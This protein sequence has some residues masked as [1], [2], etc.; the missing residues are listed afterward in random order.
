MAQ[1][2]DIA[3]RPTPF[4][5]YLALAALAGYTMTTGNFVAAATTVVAMFL[6]FG[7]KHHY[8][9]IEA[10]DSIVAHTT[11]FGL[12]LKKQFVRLADY[13]A[14]R[15]RIHF[16]GARL[17]GHSCITEL[18]RPDG[19]ILILREELI[20]FTNKIPADAEALLAKVAEITKLRKG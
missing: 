11:L 2:I 13:S 3:H 8:V 4:T 15:N 1:S 9:V 10:A 17:S 6:L 18:V 19:T 7:Y 14:V 5:V 16:R 20:G 12:D